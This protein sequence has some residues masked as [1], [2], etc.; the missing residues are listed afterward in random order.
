MCGSGNEE[1]LGVV[2]GGGG[3]RGG[4]G[5][6][7]GPTGR[8]GEEGGQ[9]ERGRGG[10]RGRAAPESEEGCWEGE[11]GGCSG[12]ETGHG[13]EEAEDEVIGLEEGR[14]TVRLRSVWC[15]TWIS[16]LAAA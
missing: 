6:D 11:D 15:K 16:E 1:V 3:Q 5:P 9:D 8:E 2:A 4:G 10:Q 7:V 14:A 13:A 12:R